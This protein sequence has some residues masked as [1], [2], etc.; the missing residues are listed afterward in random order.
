M[1]PIDSTLV[2]KVAPFDGISKERSPTVILLHGRGADEDDLLGLT[3]YLNPR[4]LII[5]ARAPFSF[6]YGGQTWYDILG[7]GTPHP[8]QFKESYERLEQFVKD[9]KE[10]YSVD[11]RNLFLLGFSMGTVMSYAYSLTHPDE[12][13]G[14]VAHSG[15]I[16]EDTPLKF[17]WE[18]LSGKGFL[19]AHG[20]QDPVIGIES[21]R[22][23]KD[24]LS[25][26]KADVTY[27]E[28]EFPH[29]MS[30]ESVNDFSQWLTMRVVGG[31]NGP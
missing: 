26:T 13:S 4:F 18:K 31:G 2:H 1:N 10:H 6:S 21:S 29:T 19:I 30:E 24:L 8:D 20:T 14:V 17:Q 15:Y 27:K 12:V 23:A 3:P 5:A 28:Y 22:R 16:P 7:N 11:H 9:V 25:R